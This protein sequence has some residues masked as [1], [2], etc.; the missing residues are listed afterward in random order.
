MGDPD[1]ARDNRFVDR[2]EAGIGVSGGFLS[3]LLGVG[4]GVILVPLLVLLG[5]RSQRE[6]HAMS[7]GAIVPISLAGVI[8]FGIAGEVRVPE[9]IALTAGALVG[10]LFGARKLSGARERSLK[11]A[12]GVFLLAVAALMV[13]GR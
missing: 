1:Q 11:L 13:A 9:A 4:G 3:G 5:K 8:T 7:L 12:F 10:A 6:A 2:T